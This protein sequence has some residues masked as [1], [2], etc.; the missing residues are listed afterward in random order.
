MSNGALEIF[1]KLDGIE[2]EST[3][4]GH[5][6]ETVVLSYEQGIEQSTSTGTGTGGSAG[7]ASFSTVRF[8]KPVDKGSIPLLLAC[9][10]GT[11]IKDARFTFRRPVTGID[12]YKVVLTD[13][14]VARIVQRAGTGAQYPLSFDELTAGAA[15]ADFLDEVALTYAKIQWEYVPI[16]PGGAPGTPIKG[17]W[18]LKLN[19]KI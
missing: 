12:F 10:S 2:G 17:G 15:S 7:R 11:H 18:D 1:V 16:G 13:V 5:A 3:V 4:K 6:K 8:R 9:A 19:K 14:V